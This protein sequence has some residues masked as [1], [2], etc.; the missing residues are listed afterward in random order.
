VKAITKSTIN[1][2]C[3]DPSKYLRPYEDSLRGSV[4]SGRGSF[5]TIDNNKEVDTSLN[6]ISFNKILNRKK[7]IEEAKMRASMDGITLSKQLDKNLFN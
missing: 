4:V 3:Y 1:P 6:S 7:A 2:S 5:S